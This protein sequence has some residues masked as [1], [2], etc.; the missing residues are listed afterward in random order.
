VSTPRS[1]ARWLRGALVGACSAVVTVAAHGAGHGALPSGPTLVVA[2]LACA[3]IGAALAGVTLE[4]RSH[5]L[6]GV[7]G[8]LSVAQALGHVV[9]TVASEHHHGGALGASP[10]MIAAHAAGAVLLGLAI[11][12]AEYLYVVCSSVLTWLRLLPVSPHRTDAP[13][14]FDSKDV[15]A[16]SVLHCYGLGMRAPPVPVAR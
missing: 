5:R 13:R 7:I 3:S 16:Q 10:A 15:V 14:R 8:A 4:S 2:S 11:A 1:R 9:L 6:L 12:S